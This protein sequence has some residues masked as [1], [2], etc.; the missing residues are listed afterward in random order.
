MTGI[1]HDQA[2]EDNQRRGD[3]ELTLS[4]TAV[5]GIFFGLVLLC[6]LCF[7]LGF[8]VGRHGSPAPAT[9]PVQ[10]AATAQTLPAD[11]SRPKPSPTSQTASAQQP[12]SPATVPQSSEPDT[13][14]APNPAVSSPTPGNSWTVRQALPPGANTGQQATTSAAS[15]V[16][17]A[18]VPAGALMVQIAAVT[19]PEDADVLVAALQKRGYTVVARRAA[20]DGLIHV[21]TGPFANRNDAN[22]MRQKL[23]NDG[24]NAIV[25][26]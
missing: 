18:M 4:S 26:P 12:P 22:E 6:G 5:F 9:A 8:A 2:P 1:L 24:Y 7:G 13:L 20:I 25:Q 3:T 10:T 14:A 15:A 16:G 19:H 11:L 21:Q 23:L 17:Q